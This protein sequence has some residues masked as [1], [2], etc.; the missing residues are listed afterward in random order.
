MCDGMGW[1]YCVFK[2]LD[3]ETRRAYAVGVTVTDRN[4]LQSAAS[5]LVIRVE[6]VNEPPVFVVDVDLP[7]W[8]VPEGI[9]GAE[10]AAAVG[11]AEVPEVKVSPYYGVKIGPPIL[12]KDPEPPPKVT[13][14]SVQYYVTSPTTVDTRGAVTTAEDLRRFY[15]DQATGQLHLLPLALIIPSA[16]P[17]LTPFVCETDTVGRTSS[18]TRNFEAG[19]SR[20]S[21]GSMGTATGSSIEPMDFESRSSYVERKKERSKQN[22]SIIRKKERISLDSRSRATHPNDVYDFV[23]PGK[24]HI[25]LESFGMGPRVLA[26][27]LFILFI[28]HTMG[29]VGDDVAD[30]GTVSASSARTL[31]LHACLQLLM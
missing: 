14:P 15:I 10:G 17:A 30:S 26:F 22:K 21:P 19:N 2:V 27:V 13:I 11:A 5:T 25:F 6:D 31:G 3:Y 7:L 9:T 28:F 18:C 24:N 29:V 16:P 20:Q 12:A 23:H 1:R 4:G 8:T